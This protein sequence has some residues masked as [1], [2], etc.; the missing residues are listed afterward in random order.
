[1]VSR[2]SSPPVSARVELVVGGALAFVGALIL[3]TRIG[4]VPGFIAELVIGFVSVPDFWPMLG[5]VVLLV[6]GVALVLRG[7]RAVRRYRRA[8]ARIEQ[9]QE[10]QQ[11]RQRGASGVS[12]GVAGTVHRAPQRF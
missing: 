11:L 7:R 8:V 3:V 12:A 2:V 4:S 5:G 1:M 6:V 10:R 9:Q